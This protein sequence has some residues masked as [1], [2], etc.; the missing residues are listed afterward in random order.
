M[1]RGVLNVNYHYAF[2][3]QIGWYNEK[4]RSFEKLDDEV[5]RE[6]VKR[7]EDQQ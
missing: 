6:A 3:S 4:E 2:G 5:C 1:A 7:V